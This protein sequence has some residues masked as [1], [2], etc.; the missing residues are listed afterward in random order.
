MRHTDFRDIVN[1]ERK[2]NVN[3]FGVMQINNCVIEMGILHLCTA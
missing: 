1:N 2:K 3:A